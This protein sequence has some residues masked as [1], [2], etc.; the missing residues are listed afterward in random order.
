MEIVGVAAAAGVGWG[1]VMALV[2]W[3]REG[4]EVVLLQA[5]ILVPAW[6]FARA[7]REARAGALAGLVLVGAAVYTFELLP[8]WGVEAA[9]RREAPGATAAERDAV[10]AGVDRDDIALFS[11]LLV[12]ALVG[13]AGGLHGARRPPEPEPA[14]AAVAAP[15]PPPPPDEPPVPLW[16]GYGRP[17]APAPPADPWLTPPPPAPPE[18]AAPRA[19][20]TPWGTA[21]LFA[22]FA[23]D[24]FLERLFDM[25]TGP[26]A[27]LALGLLV[28]GCGATAWF[29]RRRA[30]AMVVAGAVLASGFAAVQHAEY[31]ER[32]GPAERAER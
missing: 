22:A 31:Q 21:F 3:L 26:Q 9:L 28:A 15:S 23:T 29:A 7:T 19:A 6:F 1:I 27:G 16:A 4:S 14:A 13:L 12:G 17:V 10:T 2:A 8:M 5:F 25:Y 32:H 11:T 20:G 18:A 30:L 24:L